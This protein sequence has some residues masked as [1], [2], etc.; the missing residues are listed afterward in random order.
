MPASADTV[1]SAP[2]DNKCGTFGGCAVPISAS[3][4]YPKSGKMQLFDFSEDDKHTPKAIAVIEFAKG[5]PV[6]AVAYRAYTRVM[7]HR[8]KEP[9][10]QPPP[11]S[12]VRLAF[13]PS[14]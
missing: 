2:S 7:Q 3:Q 1:Y 9:P 12:D 11:P 8:H 13:P 5:E 10:A 14:T 6:H 4:I